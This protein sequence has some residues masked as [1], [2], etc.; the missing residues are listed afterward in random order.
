MPTKLNPES[1]VARLYQSEYAFERHRHRYEFNNE[2]K[3]DFESVGLRF[4]GIYEEKNL[5]EIVEIPS[6][7]FFVASQFH[8][9]FT[10]RPNKPN[11]LF[12]GFI[13]AIVKNNN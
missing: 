4:S 6:L 8:P 5:V 12:K 10:S 7:K 2:F 3:K 11:P 13:E 9:E 1:I